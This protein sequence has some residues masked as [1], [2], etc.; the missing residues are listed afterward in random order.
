MKKLGLFLCIIAVFISCKK[1][2][3]N[4]KRYCWDCIVKS[5]NYDNTQYEQK[6]KLC[7]KTKTEI[8]GIENSNYLIYPGFEYCTT[9][10]ELE[11]EYTDSISLSPIP[12]SEVYIATSPD[13]YAILRTINNSVSY[14]YTPGIP[15]HSFF[16]FGFG[17]VLIYRDLDGRLRSCDLACPVEASRE[18]RVE[19]NMPYAVCPVCNSKFDLSWGFANPISGPSKNPLF[20]YKNIRESAYTI[21]VSN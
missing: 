1:E 18:I 11:S 5:Y 13:E 7:D 16:R 21:V 3:E 10:C 17:G 9:K 19:V 20:I 14:I 2:S 6:I 15:E 8:R 12:N 4:E